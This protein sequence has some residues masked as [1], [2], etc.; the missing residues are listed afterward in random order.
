MLQLV[1]LSN[2]HA[3]LCK[4]LV[5]ID[6]K[7]QLILKADSRTQALALPIPI[8]PAAFINLLPIKTI[9]QLKVVESLFSA[10]NKDC[11]TLKDNLVS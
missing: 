9:D 2:S 5:N 3:K 6:A 7:L 11:I 4:G 1:M 8:I 10:D